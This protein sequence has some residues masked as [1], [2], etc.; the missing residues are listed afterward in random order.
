MQFFSGG[1]MQI[2]RKCLKI[3]SAEL[4]QIETWKFHTVLRLKYLELL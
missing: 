1:G 3:P 4:N 2:D